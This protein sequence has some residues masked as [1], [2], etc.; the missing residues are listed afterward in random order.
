MTGH[1][2]QSPS[3]SG[4]K[5]R[6]SSYMHNALK[7]KATTQPYRSKRKRS[8]FENPLAAIDR[9]RAARSHPC[10]VS[11]AVHSNLAGTGPRQGLGVKKTNTACSHTI[12]SCER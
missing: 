12:R 4:D 5:K 3:S 8:V 6:Q 2:A 10:V 11:D 9:M 7:R 1:V